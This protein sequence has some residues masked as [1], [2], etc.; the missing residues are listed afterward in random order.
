MTNYTTSK[1][2][3]SEIIAELYEQEQRLK[4]LAKD[5]THAFGDWRRIYLDDA[6]T[7]LRTVMNWLQ[8]IKENWDDIN[9]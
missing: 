9:P 2:A 5:R 3:L 7:R 6:T 8:Y 4:A 1:I